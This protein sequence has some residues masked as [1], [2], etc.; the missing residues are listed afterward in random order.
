MILHTIETNFERKNY[1]MKTFE[2][3]L[4]VLGFA[5]L[6]GTAVFADDL[7][8]EKTILIPEREIKSVNKSRSLDL[9]FIE[10]NYS[11][12][13]IQL[14]IPEDVFAIVVSIE[15]EHSEVWSGVLTQDIPYSS[16]P[17]LYGE[18][19]ITCTTDNGDIYQSIIVF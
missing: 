10:C 9:L 19:V 7:E 12:G 15:D 5:A 13:Y 1:C 18:Y 2:K 11:D 16:I 6:A 17:Y 3:F 8:L 14:G 4:F